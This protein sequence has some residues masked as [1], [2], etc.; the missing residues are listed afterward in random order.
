MTYF[1]RKLTRCWTSLR[2]FRIIYSSV[3]TVS[4]PQYIRMSVR[5]IFFSNLQCSTKQRDFIDWSQ[6]KKNSLNFIG[7]WAR[8]YINSLSLY[9]ELPHSSL[10]LCS[11]YLSLTIC[12]TLASEKFKKKLLQDDTQRLNKSL[13]SPIIPSFKRQIQVKI[14]IINDTNKRYKAFIS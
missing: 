3:L 12:F 1:N 11:F 6:W 14:I 2:A 9:I 10:V 13:I 4:E 8:L 7:H 5:C